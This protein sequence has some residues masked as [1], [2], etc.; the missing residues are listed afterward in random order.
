[1]R[2]VHA[3]VHKF[4]L[5]EP[6]SQAFRMF[7][8]SSGSVYRGSFF[9]GWLVLGRM[10]P[11]TRLL[12][13]VKVCLRESVPFAGACKVLLVSSFY[14]KLVLLFL[15]YII[16]TFDKKKKRAGVVNSLGAGA[17]IDTSLCLSSLSQF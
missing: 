11:S 2:T 8:W 14:C 4:L 5:W 17:V 7:G 6:G 1:M 10:F 13:F 3:F 9:S 15:I 12:C 16:L